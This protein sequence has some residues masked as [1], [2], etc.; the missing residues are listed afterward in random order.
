MLLG[1]VGWLFVG[2]SQNDKEFELLRRKVTFTFLVASICITKVLYKIWRS[3]YPSSEVTIAFLYR[4]A[5]H[6]NVL[7]LAWLMNFNLTGTFWSPL[8]TLSSK[9]EWFEGVFHVHVIQ[10]EN[11]LK[12]QDEPAVKRKIQQNGSSQVQSL[13]SSKRR[14]WFVRGEDFHV[15]FVSAFI[16]CATGVPKFHRQTLCFWGP[17]GYTL[18]SIFNSKLSQCFD[19]T[20]TVEVLMVSQQLPSLKLT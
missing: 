17:L 19:N 20:V 15:S 13:T 8:P 5:P 9:I 3:K 4:I 14:K 1:F 6:H 10:W 7:V 11:L 16:V 12:V 2:G 18:I